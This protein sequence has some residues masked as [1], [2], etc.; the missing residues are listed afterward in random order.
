MAVKKQP[1]NIRQEIEAVNRYTESL[2]RC[3]AANI[4]VSPV[5]GLI[6]SFNGDKGSYS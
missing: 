5:Q 4:D 1:L 2:L 6:E 3:D